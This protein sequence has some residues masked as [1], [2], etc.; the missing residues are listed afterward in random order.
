MRSKTVK[1][2]SAALEA[3]VTQIEQQPPGP[4]YQGVFQEGKTYSRGSRV[5]KA[6][7]LWLAARSSSSLTNGLRYT[8]ATCALTGRRRTPS[9]AVERYRGQL[10]EQLLRLVIKNGPEWFGGGERCEAVEALPSSGVS[11]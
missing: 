4:H 3:R 6:G 8:P 7:G 1:G 9:G 10:L 2:R 11:H 5:T